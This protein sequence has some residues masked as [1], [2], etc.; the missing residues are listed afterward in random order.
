MY[1]GLPNSVYKIAKTLA[2]EAQL[3]E[4]ILKKA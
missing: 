4:K 3:L 2:K 1:E